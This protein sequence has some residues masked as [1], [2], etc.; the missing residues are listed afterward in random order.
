[1]LHLASNKKKKTEENQQSKD[2]K[3]KID[4]TIARF[5][6]GCNI[7]FKV[8]DS[9]YFRELMVLLCPEYPV[10]Q[11]QTLASKLLDEAYDDIRASQKS[12][13]SRK[14]TL[15]IDGWKNSVTN[16]KL[17]VTMVK[18]RGEKEILIDC[19]DYTDIP[20][21]AENFGDTITTA[22]EIAINE[23][24]I[25][26]EACGSDNEK[27]IRK[28]CR[29]SNL[30]SFG[31]PAHLFDLAI[32]SIHNCSIGAKVRSVHTFI[33][34]FPKLQDRVIKAG[35]SA[36]I[37]R[38]ATRW[39]GEKEELQCFSKNFNAI[40]Q[41]MEESADQDFDEIHDIMTDTNL[42]REVQEEILV[43]TPLCNMVD[44]A[45]RRE[46][47]L[48]EA[49]EDWTHVTFC[50]SNELKNRKKQLD[51]M[52]Y[53]ETSLTSNILDH[54]FKGASLTFEQNAKVDEFLRQK[55]RSTDE[56]EIFHEFK[57][58]DGA[59][60]DETITELSPKLFW[61][62]FY[63]YAPALSEI[64]QLYTSLPASTAG[65]ERSFSQ[66]SYVHD[67][68]RNRL[69]VERSR[70][71]FFVYHALTL[72]NFDSDSILSSTL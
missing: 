35:G 65:L 66:W 46:S 44:K 15:L 64:A 54:R 48:S 51:K 41:V 13:E 1:M 8:I 57:R 22:R 69:G 6:F 32:N 53:C 29:E 28:A 19:E 30:P 12:A 68:L 7:P 10:P 5:F 26:V 61:Q 47:K 55:L 60:S 3:N 4:E 43:L 21:N 31:C 9:P 71:L 67:K 40:T 58:G 49:I 24:N 72:S 38:G 14:G 11:R 33:R 27:A 2:R 16:R 63:D 52:F 45:Q 50:D 42:L 70:K 56:Y 18:P 17:L 39:K 34:K 62:F 59:F 25:E 23:L 20:G 37:I 36:L